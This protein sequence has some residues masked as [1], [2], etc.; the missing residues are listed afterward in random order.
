MLLPLL[1]CSGRGVQKDKSLWMCCDANFER[2]TDQDSVRFYLDKARET[3]FNRIVVDVKGAGGY[4]LYE[5]DFL[6]K[7]TKEGGVSFERD[8]DYLDFFIREAHRRGMKVSVSLTPFSVGTPC[9]GTGPCY[10]DPSLQ[11]H[12]CLE[13]RPEG[14]IKIED[15][16]TQVSA[17]LNP[18]SSFAHDFAIRTVREVLDRYDFDGLC[19]DY[20]RYPNMYADFSEISR[21]K[22]ESY[23]GCELDRFP[24]DVLSYDEA[25]EVVPGIYYKE[26]WQWRATV[27]RDYVAE[28]SGIVHNEYPGVQLEYWAASWLHALWGTGQNWASSETTAY[29]EGLPWAAEDYNEAGF[30]QYLDLFVV[31]TYLER[32]WGMEDLESIEYGLWRADRD[33]AGA[34]RL[35]G[36]ITGTNTLDEFDDAVYLCMKNTSGVMVFDLVWV[37]KNDL[38]DKI[39]AGIDR[40]ESEL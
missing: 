16:R 24:E 36:S 1:G 18:T 26:W 27:I 38:W 40:A 17:F 12:T 34:C 25:G 14:M 28:I 21:Q 39:K 7:L 9:Y 11:Q 35:Q 3:G 30:A 13:Y 32:V 22:F 31:G 23:L 8:W 29:Y 5:S 19:L 4:V 2:F 33:I 37:I 6:P 20:C 10:D 15:D